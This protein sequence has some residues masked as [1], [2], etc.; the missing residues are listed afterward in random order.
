LTRPLGLLV[1]VGCVVGGFLLAGGNLVTLVQPAEFVVIGGAAIGS[2][3]ISLSGPM[4]KKLR[5]RLAGVFGRS[6]YGGA[7][8]AEL[9]QLLYHLTIVVKRE[10]VIALENHLRDP[11]TSTIFSAYP[12]ILRNPQVMRF[13]IEALMMQ[14]DGAVGPE[15]LRGILERELETHHAEDSVPGAVL[16]KMGD[17]LPGLGIVAAVLGII[18]TMG[19]IDEGPAMVGHHV[20]AALVGTFLGVLISYGFVQP[21]VSAMEQDLR[22]EENF[23]EAIKIGMIAFAQGKAPVV[24][25]EVARRSLFAY[26]RPQRES[27][28]EACKALR[29]A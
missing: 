15:D 19:K 4:L 17:A 25:V 10:G 24:V 16:Q 9:L 11:E 18:I 27:V 3:L 5:V 2:L 7:S 1:V 26:N 12:A 29:A 14:V 23:Y 8:A 22:D 6:P 20:A 28:E 21:L 13:I